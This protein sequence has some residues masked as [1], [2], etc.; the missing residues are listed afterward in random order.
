MRPEE[1][2]TLARHLDSARLEKR[3]VERLTLAHPDLTLEEA[4]AIQE[5]GIALRHARGE[6]TL[7]LKM[8]L[9]SEAKR[10]QMGL[11]SPVFGELTTAMQVPDGGVFPLE[12]SIHPKIEPEIAFEIGRDLQGSIT[13]EEA[14]QAC[15][16]AFAAMEILD[17]RY[18]DFK[19]F[20]LPDVVAD[21]S[22]SSHF[23]IAAEGRPLAGLSLETLPIR[24]EVN[25][26]TKQTAVG[27]AISGHPL[28]SV[29]Q[30][31]ELLAQRGRKLPKGSIVMA[32]AATIAEVL[33]PGDR[34][35][36]TIE[37]LGTVEVTV[38]AAG[39]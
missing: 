18:R 14:A 2:N 1:I 32:G 22:S 24:M 21:N 7:G 33:E 8:G 5:A 3:S 25:G 6:T 9:T 20:S 38:A 30:L 11:D 16:R 31:C 4:Y 36:T 10:K 29:V 15:T 28:R 17:S 23:V 26:E 13:L 12:G 35:R 19:Y 27:S 39:E 37:G 34:I